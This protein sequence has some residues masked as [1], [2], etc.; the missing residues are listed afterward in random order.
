MSKYTKIYN[1]QNN[2]EMTNLNST[3][4]L[5]DVEKQDNQ[6]K[7]LNCIQNILKYIYKYIQI[8]CIIMRLITLIMLIIVI[9]HFSA[10]IAIYLIMI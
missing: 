10:Q 6:N 7:K 9:Y 4:T 3:T 1:D 5:E 8:I 2:I